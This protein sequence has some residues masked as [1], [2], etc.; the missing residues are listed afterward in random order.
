MDENF[1]NDSVHDI[2]DKTLEML[3]RSLFKEAFTYGFTQA[4]YLRFVNMFLDLAMKQ[5]GAVN[6]RFPDDAEDTSWKSMP[7]AAQMKFPLI[8]DHIKIRQFDEKSD[9]DIFNT[10]LQDTYGR[11]FI[12]S[13]STARTVTL[14]ELVHDDSNVIGVV[15]LPDNTPIGSVAFLDY[16]PDQRKAE[17]RKLIGEPSMRGKGYAKEAT[18]FWIQY[19]L[20][21][22]HLK[23]NLPQHH[24]H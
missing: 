16:N 14:D 19:G 8:G 11:Y 5:N 2:P 22:L 1:L 3:A 13:R 20:R 18:Q 10:W 4:D 12:L 23:K 15:T 24:R 21:T 7:P 6:L 17:L 9:W